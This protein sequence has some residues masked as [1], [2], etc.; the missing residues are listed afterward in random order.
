MSIKKITGEK[1][2]ATFTG[3]PINAG[4]SEGRGPATGLGGFYVFDALR[5]ELKLPEKCNVVIQGFGNV[6]GNAAEIFTAHGHNVI[7][8]SD[9]KGGIY[10]A[11][12]ID[13]KKIT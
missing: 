5:E 3:K 13:I 10:K 9:S 11:D 2:D 8:I 4:G 6:G 1:T 12:G 7:A